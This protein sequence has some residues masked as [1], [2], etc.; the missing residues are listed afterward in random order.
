MHTKIYESTLLEYFI[1]LVAFKKE[2]V[3][4][5]ES[6][7]EMGSRRGEKEVRGE[8]LQEKFIL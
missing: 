3:Y 2:L 5:D 7:E 4:R 8:Y 6:E 1:A